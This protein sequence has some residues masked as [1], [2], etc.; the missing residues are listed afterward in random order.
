[1]D[2]KN[3]AII[4]ILIAVVFFIVRP[5]PSQEPNGTPTPEPSPEPAPEPSPEPA[6]EPAP[7]PTGNFLFLDTYEDN[8]TIVETTPEKWREFSN[9][10]R[11]NR[12]YWSD[13]TY[14]LEIGK[15]EQGGKYSVDHSLGEASITTKVTYSGKK[16]IELTLYE[17]PSGYVEHGAA[18]ARYIRNTSV[19]TDGVYEIGVWFYVPAGY[20][21]RYVHVS[22]EDHLTWTKGYLV[23]AG[24]DPESNKIVA[25]V[26]SE[27]DTRFI[28]EPIGEI[29]FHYDTW[30]KLWITYDTQ[31]P[32]TYEIG[33]KSPT[34][35]KIFRTDKLIVQGMALGFIDLPSFNFYA[36]AANVPGRPE[37]KLY[38]DDFYVKDIG[39]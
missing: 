25:W 8:P 21:P 13:I 29:D 7:E 3:I 34:E 32:T 17:T 9:D 15:V 36:G 39:T 14:W 12:D 37:Q 20:T 5:R 18:L 1:M 11:K 35:E 19:A 2:R 22:I 33:Y 38:V 26:Q 10:A 30:F 31:K 23:H 16:S 24:V 4:I 6:P 28:W 27:G